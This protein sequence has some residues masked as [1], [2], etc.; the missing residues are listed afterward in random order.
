MKTENV[1][2]SEEFSR[3]TR[4]FFAGILSHFKKKW[5]GSAQK[6]PLSGCVGSFQIH[7]QKPEKCLKKQRAGCLLVPKQ[8]APG[9]VWQRLA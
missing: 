9:V 7:P 2:G 4:H 3:C 8:Q 6:G 1:T 5:N